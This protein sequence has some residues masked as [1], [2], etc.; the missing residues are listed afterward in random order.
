MTDLGVRYLTG[1]NR[2][3]ADISSRRQTGCTQLRT[4]E[5]SDISLSLHTLT[6]LLI[7]LPHLTILSAHTRWQRHIANIPHHRSQPPP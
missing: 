4:A 3:A 6:L 1:I 7:H 2:T 5:L